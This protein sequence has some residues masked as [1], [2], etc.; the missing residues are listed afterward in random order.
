MKK[1]H[2]KSI[3]LCIALF[4]LLS[5]FVFGGCFLLKEEEIDPFANIP[6]IT[7]DDDTQDADENSNSIC[8]INDMRA[9]KTN[10]AGR[11]VSPFDQELFFEIIDDQI[12]L[13]VAMGKFEEEADIDYF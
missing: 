1:P 2:G 11:Y 9:D 8:I 13:G 4:A 12:E 3:V 6:E 7:L 5:V 10:M